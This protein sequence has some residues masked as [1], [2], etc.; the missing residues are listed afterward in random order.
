[1]DAAGREFKFNS[2]LALNNKSFGKTYGAWK[3]I[4]EYPRRQVKDHIFIKAT[5][6]SDRVGGILDI[7]DAPPIP[8]YKFTILNE[9]KSE[10]LFLCDSKQE[11]A[12]KIHV[13]HNTFNEQGKEHFNTVEGGLISGQDESRNKYN[14][15]VRMTLPGDESNETE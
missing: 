12:T 4:F 10:I 9:D 3:P 15:W 6:D 7:D 14:Y 13:R 11:A 8:N 2:T 1:M 5:E